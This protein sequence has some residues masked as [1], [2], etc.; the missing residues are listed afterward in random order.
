MATTENAGKPF[1]KWA[2][3]KS[4][5]LGALHAASPSEW[6]T[7]HEPFT[8][9]GA[10]FFEL[11]SQD[12]ISRA[13]LSDSNPDLIN[14]YRVVRDDLP[15]LLDELMSL[16]IQYLGAR[17]RAEVYYAIRAQRR[18]DPVGSA[19]RLIFLNR[20]CFNGLYRV[21]QSGEFNVPH[22]RY[23]R[24]RVCD[25]G[26]LRRA[27]A[28]LA[29]AR[30]EIS[31]FEAASDFVR[32]GDFVYFDPPYH[33]VSDTASFTSYT[34]QD[35]DWADQVRLAGVAQSLATE[36]GAHVLVSNS[37]HAD[38]IGL[39]RE[40][41]FQMEEA[42]APRSINSKGDRRGPVTE[43]L[44]LS[45]SRDP[46]NSSPKKNRSH[47]SRSSKSTTLPVPRR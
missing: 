10:L 22:G 20:T 12:R 16:E 17:D 9:G 45:Y 30:L 4:R 3:G 40:R 32:A 1:L 41:G 25:S 7:Y 6:A 47:V 38:V 5:L 19:A 33:P 13:V 18:T 43:L 44:A 39:Y 34:A 31:D 27:S 8:G 15:L 24:P 35:F 21:N 28:L 2:G 23:V 46:T 37:S 36:R 42:A 26:G 29:L 11:A 14:A